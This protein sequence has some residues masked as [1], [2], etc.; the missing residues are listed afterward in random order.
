MLFSCFVDFKKAFDLVPRDI[1]LEKLLKFGIN[2]NFFN[3]I[4]NIYIRT[5][6]PV[7][8]LKE[9]AATPFVS[10]LV[11]VRVVFLVLYFL[12]FFFVT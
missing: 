4:R 3:I 11:C 10:I 9:N 8:K 6:K 12:T 7:L 5:T 2:G 1:L